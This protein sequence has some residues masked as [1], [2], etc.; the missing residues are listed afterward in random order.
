MNPKSNLRIIFHIWDI[1]T[2]YE[3]YIPTITI[4]RKSVFILL[5]RYGVSQ[6]SIRIHGCLY[7]KIFRRRL[8]MIM[9]CSCFYGFEL[10][11]KTSILIPMVLLIRAQVLFVF[12]IHSSHI[13]KTI[14]IPFS[15]GSQSATGLVE[16]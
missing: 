9:L 10:F 2:T 3:S 6:Q 16:I 8:P 11:F 5:L 12:F 7:G 14:N 4:C 1:L 13:N 15:A